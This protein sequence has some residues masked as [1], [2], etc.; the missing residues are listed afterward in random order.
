VKLNKNGGQRRSAGWEFVHVC[1]EDATRLAYLEVLPDEGG[2]HGRV[3]E[4]RRQL[5]EGNGIELER[6]LSA[7]L[8]KGRPRLGLP[9]WNNVV[10]N[11]S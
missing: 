9:S 6:V 1:V 5:V 3:P 2:H 8:A 4:P 10:S 11:Y 7:P